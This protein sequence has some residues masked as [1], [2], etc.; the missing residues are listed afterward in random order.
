MFYGVFKLHYLFSIMTFKKAPDIDCDA[1]ASHEGK[2]GLGLLLQKIIY[3]G[4]ISLSLNYSIYIDLEG[5]QVQIARKPIRVL[6]RLKRIDK[7]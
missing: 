1:Q 4:S 7:N 2:V 5:S 3:W 6:R